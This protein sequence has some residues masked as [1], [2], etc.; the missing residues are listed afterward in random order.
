MTSSNGQRLPIE[1]LVSCR[2][3]ALEMLS[4]PAFVFLAESLEMHSD[5][6]CRSH[7]NSD[8][9]SCPLM[10]FSA[11]LLNCGRDERGCMMDSLDQIG[12]LNYVSSKSSTK[13]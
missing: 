7:L 5:N 2:M 8:A 11:T 6:S 1:V 4:M 12:G 10:K 3:I 13:G 9:S